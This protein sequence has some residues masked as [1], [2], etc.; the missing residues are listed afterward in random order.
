MNKLDFLARRTAAYFLMLELSSLLKAMNR[1]C[2]TQNEKIPLEITNHMSGAVNMSSLMPTHK[3]A[4]Y[5]CPLYFVRE[6]IDTVTTCLITTTHVDVVF[7]LLYFLKVFHG[8]MIHKNN[9]WAPH[10][11]IG[12]SQRSEVKTK[13]GDMFVWLPL[14]LSGSENGLS[15]QTTLEKILPG[16]RQELQHCCSSPA[17]STLIFYIPNPLLCHS[18][19]PRVILQ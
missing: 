10:G 12:W 3:H 14:T 9:V 15:A 4:P 13:R 2:F 16:G 1:A 17:P 11:F 18:W 8:M 19:L 7:L 6:V 5:I